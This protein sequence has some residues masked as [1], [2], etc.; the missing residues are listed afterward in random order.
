MT[1]I[2]TLDPAKG[3]TPDSQRGDGIFVARQIR[4]TRSKKDKVVLVKYP[5]T[6]EHP[7][8]VEIVDKDVPVGTVEE[9]EWS[10]LMTPADKAALIGKVE[11]VSRAIR[12]ARSRA[13]EVE[14]DLT[15]KIGENIL[16]AI[17]G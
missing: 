17:F 11:N 3:F 4:K 10:G 12:Q 2:P 13:N 1:A 6:V 15:K 5:H 9:Q 7:A 14:V 16:Q 8:Q